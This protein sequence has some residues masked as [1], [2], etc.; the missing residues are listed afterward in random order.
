MVTKKIIEC[1][2]LRGAVDSL[3]SSLFEQSKIIKIVKRASP[4]VRIQKNSRIFNI[5]ICESGKLL[6]P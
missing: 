5:E 4:G 1:D 6:T 3:F 2:F